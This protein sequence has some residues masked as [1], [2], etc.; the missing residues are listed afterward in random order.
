MPY[1]KTAFVNAGKLGD[2]QTHINPVRV[3]VTGEGELQAYLFDTGLITNATLE[4][5][6]LSLTSARS[7]NFLS[8]FTSERIC[9]TLLTSEI[10][11]YFNISN[12]WA[13]VKPSRISFP[14]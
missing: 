11:E 7:I 1:I 2:I 12:I 9:I 10:D 14:Q 5:Q 4:P 8:N 13:Y 6:T 3:R